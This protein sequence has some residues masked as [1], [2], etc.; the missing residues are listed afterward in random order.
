MKKDNSNKNKKIGLFG[1][2]AFTAASMMSMVLFPTFASSGF[3]LIFFLVMAAFFWFIPIAIASAEMG[4]IKVW[5]NGGVFEWVKNTLGE[6]WG[7]AAVFY[8]WFQT[9]IIYTIFFYF[10][11]S[12]IDYLF[13]TTFLD[14]IWFQFLI[15]IIAFVLVTFI[16]L[17]GIKVTTTITKFSLPLGVILPTILLII[18]S[19]SFAFGRGKVDLPPDLDLNVFPVGGIFQ[20]V[21]FSSF[22]LSMTAIEVS[23]NAINIL[24]NS[25]KNYPIVVGILV[26]LLITLIT[27]AGLS[28]ALVMPIGEIGLSDAIFLTFDKIIRGLFGAQHIWISKLITVLILFG[29]I[30]QVSA[31]IVEPSIGVSKALETLNAP[32]W[33]NKT[34]KYDVK[35]NILIIQII[36]MIIWLSIITFTTIGNLPMTICIA[37]TSSTYLLTY[38]LML[39]SHIKLSI[40]NTDLERSFGIKNKWIK[41]TISSIGLILTIFTLAIMF[42]KPF[43]G[44][45]DKE[46]LIYFLILSLSISIISIS[47]FI[48]YK[49][50]KIKS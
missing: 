47:P 17:F 35:Y 45:S 38:V 20:F 3:N 24:K 43:E 19:F 5:K 33:I 22:L 36:L 14:N 16:N 9:T 26:I 42:F 25:K 21:I 6:K 13:D 8:Q 18:L 12:G 50:L 4:S 48:I 29:T 32:K 10:L 39:I 41:I 15:I 7:F 30:G 34:N 31:I 23:A 28:I 40:K 11:T 46:Y 44:I 37:I 2:F 27:L 49:I 1:F